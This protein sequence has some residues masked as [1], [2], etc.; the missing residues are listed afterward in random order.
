MP[1]KIKSDFAAEW[2][3]LMALVAVDL[4]WAHAIGFHL[5]ISWSNGKLIGLGLL[6][7]LLLRQFWS[8]GGLIA[9]YFS[10][11]TAATA[12]FAVLSYLCLASSGALVD[13]SLQAYDCA[14]GFDWMTGYRF[15]L[16]HPRIVTVLMFAYN[17]MVYQG[18]YFGVL[19]ALM[20][21]KTNLREMFWL[22]M[23]MGLFT[24]LGVLLFPALGPFKQYAT[25]PAG[26][27]L[28]EMDRIKSGHDLNFALDKLT[29]VVSFPSFHTAMALAYIW[30]FRNTSAIGW[31]IAL[32]NLLMLCAIP[33]FGGHYLS[34]MIAGASVM[35]VSLTLVKIARRFWTKI[36]EA[37]ASPGYAAAS[38]DAY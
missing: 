20:G 31:G 28:P 37:S 13:G 14:L 5:S 10:L 15:L 12:T 32:L 6:C 27:F 4:S 18:L 36:S 38:G 9:E 16:A 33:W 30:G 21:K 17:S 29:G 7:A 35:L 25:A 11:S 3:A 24:S 8:R 2:L 23:A 26:S 34:D 19:F 22:V 1:G